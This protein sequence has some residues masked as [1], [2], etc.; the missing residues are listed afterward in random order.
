MD[1]WY[2]SSSTVIDENKMLEYINTRTQQKV[3]IIRGLIETIIGTLLPLLLFGTLLV[4][5]IK[6]RWILKNPVSWF[7]IA[8][9]VFLI[10]IGGV[11][12]NILHKAPMHGIKKSDSGELEYEYISTGVFY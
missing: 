2:F 12:Y 10:C 3:V 11:V 6:F 7:V 9:T 4:A 8:C 5:V 1:T